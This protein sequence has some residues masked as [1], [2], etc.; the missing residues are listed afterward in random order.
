MMRFLRGA[1]KTATGEPHHLNV[2]S[3]LTLKPA[4]RLNAVEI[5]VEISSEIDQRLVQGGPNLRQ[6]VKLWDT[7][8]AGEQTHPLLGPDTGVITLQNGVD[9]VERTC[10]HRDS[11][12]IGGTTHVVA[13]LVQPAVTLAPWQNP[14]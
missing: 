5:L 4:A 7:E 6:A 1:T 10:S 8:T 14:L 13:R 2:A 12:T 11:S 3:N 9:S